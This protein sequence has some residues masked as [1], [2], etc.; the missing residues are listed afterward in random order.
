M[1]A[2]RHMRQGVMHPMDAT[3]LPGRTENAGY[4][5]AEAVMSIR[6]HQLDALETTFDQA[7]QEDRPERLRFRRTDTEPDDLTPALGSHPDGDYPKSGSWMIARWRRIG[8][9]CRDGDRNDEFGGS[10]GG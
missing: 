7:L 8:G 3:S 1:L 9:N 5:E 2:F 10:P 6:D 4:S